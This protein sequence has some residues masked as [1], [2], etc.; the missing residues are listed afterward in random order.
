MSNQIRLLSQ[1]VIDTQY[2]DLADV[3]ERHARLIRSLRAGD[4]ASAEADIREH[5]DVVARRVIRTLTER[6][7]ERVQ[8][9]RAYGLPFE[10]ATDAPLDAAGRGSGPNGGDGSV[11]NRG[12]TS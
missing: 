11:A 8:A 12:G 5:I 4:A 10:S 3:P 6:D 1:Q 7:A 9:V 2:A